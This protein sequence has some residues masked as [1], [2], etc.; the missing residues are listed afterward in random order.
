MHCLCIKDSDIQKLT[1]VGSELS[2]EEFL[3][4]ISHFMRPDFLEMQLLDLFFVNPYIFFIE[5]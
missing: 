3:L 5:L 1:Q 2:F 4:K